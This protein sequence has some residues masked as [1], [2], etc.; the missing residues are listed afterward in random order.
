M[1]FWVKLI[2]SEKQ[3]LNKFNQAT[4]MEITEEKRTKTEKKRSRIYVT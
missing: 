2:Y 3:N 1:D 4:K